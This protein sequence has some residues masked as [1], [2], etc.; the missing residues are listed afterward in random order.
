MCSTRRQFANTC[1]YLHNGCDEFLY[2]A[3]ADE[4]GPVVME[5]V[6]DEPLNV[7]AI[8]VLICHDEQ[9]AIPQTTQFRT[10]RILLAVVEAKD[11]NNVGD[12]FIVHQLQ[13]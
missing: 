2:K 5:E 11:L 1:T 4:T 10:L 12:L 13:L 9:L 3:V 7:R 6:N 8:L